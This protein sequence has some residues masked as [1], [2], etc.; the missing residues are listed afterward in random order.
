MSDFYEALADINEFQRV[1]YEG[2]QAGQKYCFIIGSGASVS[3][4]IPSGRSMVQE[5]FE[6]LKKGKDP[7]TFR[8]DIE[9]RI[10]E[11]IMKRGNCDL[12]VIKKAFSKYTDIKYVPDT[13]YSQDDY[14][15]IFELRF[16]YNEAEGKRYFLDLSDEAYP[17]AGYCALSSILC[18]GRN[19][20]IVITTNFDELIELASIIYQGKRVFSIEHENMA[21]YALEDWNGRPR[22]LKIHQGVDIGGLNKDRETEVLS[23]SWQSVLECILKDYIPIVVGYSGT[24]K[25]VMS[26]L[27]TLNLKSIYWCYLYGY[28]PN[29]RIKRLVQNNSGLMIPIHN[30][31]QLFI[32]L[33]SVMVKNKTEI[34]SVRT[35][36]DNSI[37]AYRQ[38]KLLKQ[39]KRRL[40]YSLKG[41][42]YKSYGL[43]GQLFKSND[44]K[45]RM[46]RLNVF[47]VALIFG[48]TGVMKAVL[49]K[50]RLNGEFYARGYYE[51]GKAYQRRKKYAKACDQY[52]T[53]IDG[54]GDNKYMECCGWKNLCDIYRITGNVEMLRDAAEK[55][56]RI[57]PHNAACKKILEH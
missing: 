43:M 31:D 36:Y 38:Y 15:Y 33:E 4:G 30:S 3:S 53:L 49:E 26:F 23:H 34:K 17:N 5:W 24:D 9:E 1:I 32:D 28:I 40:K 45:I 8:T 35:L 50:A 6:H 55:V 48:I 19:S 21:K 27:E 16:A 29:D 10:Q 7:T 2:M 37:A 44:P 22:V 47:E 42:E 56:I 13:E 20:D 12:S 52:Y 54:A 11:V 25:D 46:L 41:Y 14:N 39:Y 18:N 57:E 51:L